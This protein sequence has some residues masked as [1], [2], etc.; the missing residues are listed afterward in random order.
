[1][2]MMS[3]HECPTFTAT[4]TFNGK[5]VHVLTEGDAMTIGQA[6]LNERERILNELGK[7]TMMTK[8]IDWHDALAYAKRIVKGQSV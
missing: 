1:M 4:F 3:D 2:K 6:I 7:L 8:P 5:P